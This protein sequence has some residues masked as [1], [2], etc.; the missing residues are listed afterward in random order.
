MHGHCRCVCRLP[1]CFASVVR[2]L[3][4]VEKVARDDQRRLHQIIEI[5][6]LN[7][8]NDG[9]APDIIVLPCLPLVTHPSTGCAVLCAGKQPQAADADA[10][11]APAVGFCDLVR[12]VP[13]QD[14]GSP[15]WAQLDRQD[16]RALRSTCRMLDQLAREWLVRSGCIV[17]CV[18][19][20]KPTEAEE[21]WKSLVVGLQ[22][23]KRLMS[24]SLTG[25]RFCTLTRIM[26]EGG[27]RSAGCLRTLKFDRL[28][29]SKSGDHLCAALLHSS[30]HHLTD[31]SLR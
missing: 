21:Q 25:V 6:L 19:G 3:L 17:Q 9:A 5:I 15:L 26:L 13:L 8:L 18:G 10:D 30:P 14:F 29:E 1:A 24:L 11:V 22:C 28:R 20:S 7:D 2:A 12:C 4:E 23:Y 27:L 31:L 16:R